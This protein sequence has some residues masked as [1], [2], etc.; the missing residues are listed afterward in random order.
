[1]RYSRRQY[2]VS[3]PLKKTRCPTAY[4]RLKKR[5]RLPFLRR[6]YDDNFYAP[7]S[8][9]LRPKPSIE[10]QKHFDE[11]ER[12]WREKKRLIDEKSRNNR[13]TEAERATR[14]AETID[15][16]ER[17]WREEKLLIDEKSRNNRR[18]EAE[19]ASRRA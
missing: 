12:N 10:E 6:L 19:R 3:V 9:E 16:L 17:N 15:G 2:K 13:R 8:V 14:T 18:T 4:Q 11:L 1:M 5:N 7:F